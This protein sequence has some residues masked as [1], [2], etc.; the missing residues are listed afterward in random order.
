VGAT[1]AVM[2][3]SSSAAAPLETDSGAAG[4]PDEASADEAQTSASEKL[5]DKESATALLGVEVT[6]DPEIEVARSVPVLQVSTT[7]P[8]I[9]GVVAILLGL[10]TCFL[11]K[12]SGGKRRAL[13]SID[14]AGCCS[15]GCCSGYGLKGWSQGTF[16]AAIF[17]LGS[18]IPIYV[19]MTAVA[20]RLLCI[21]EQ[22]KALTEIGGD[23]AALVE[24]L[25]DAT[26]LLGTLEQ[27]LPLLGIAAI[28]PAALA[29]VFMI[30]S[31]GFAF[32]TSSTMCCAKLFALI[33]QLFC[34]LSA[35][36]YI[37]FGALG[38]AVT[39]E[40]IQPILK[41]I[42]GIC[43]T[44]IPIMA[45]LAEGAK[46]ALAMAEDVGSSAADLADIQAVVDVLVPTVETFG[47]ACDCLTELM[48]DLS[49]L[50]VPGAVA[51]IASFYGLYSVHGLCCAAKCCYSPTG[52]GNPG[53]GTT[54]S[55]TDQA[56]QD[57]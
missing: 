45:D 51:A 25:G 34:L 40:V 53:E 52:A 23:A 26:A 15:T 12:R 20:D 38:V 29:A 48:F 43:E 42:T 17:L 31:A 39:L 7:L 46:G 49:Y 10:S 50:V 32:R 57:V 2:A 14:Y 24:G 47:A 27:S 13:W 37:I 56:V 11:A 30:L 4:E 28:L 33:T 21:V 54:L 41:L 16:L 8:I 36:L 35:V 9:I 3:S 44:K 5:G 18:A 1:L 19:Q 22:V 55:K 6:E